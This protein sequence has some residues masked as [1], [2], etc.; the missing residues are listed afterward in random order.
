M[1]LTIS[2]LY[3]SHDEIKCGDGSRIVVAPKQ[4]Y[5]ISTET[6]SHTSGISSIIYSVEVELKVGGGVGIIVFTLSSII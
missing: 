2:F 6:A 3:T 4:I 5:H 1:R